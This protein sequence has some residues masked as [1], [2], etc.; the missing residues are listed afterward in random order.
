MIEQ[1]F[2]VATEFRFDVGQAMLNTQAL[3]GAVDNL[4]A[5]TDGA[6]KSLGYLAGGLVAH[7]GFGSG[8]LLSILTKAVQISEAFDSQALNFAN[9]INANMGTLSGTIGTFNERLATSQMILDNISDTAI[10]FAIPTAALAE[11]TQ[12]IAT[13]LANRGKLG[14]NFSGAIEMSKNL[15]LAAPAA[16]INPMIAGESLY[17]ALSEHQP[18]HGQLFSRLANT[19]QFKGAHITTQMQLANMQPDKKIELLSSALKGLA[20]D[21]DAINFR[22]NTLHGQF[23]ILQDIFSD[24]GSILRPIGDAIKKPLIQVLKYLTTYFA[25]HGKELGKNLGQLLSSFISDPKSALVNLMQLKSFGGD[26]K[27]ALHIVE[28][29]GTFRLLKFIITDLLGITLNGGLI[30]KM[31]NAIRTGIMWLVD[32]IPWGAVMSGVFNLLRMAALEV[33]PVFL[34][35]LGIFQIFSRAK[36]IALAQDIKNTLP[37]TERLAGVMVKLKVAFDKIMTPITTVI[38]FMANLIAPLFETTFWLKIGVPLLE[39]LAFTLDKIG[40][41]VVGLT[42]ALYGIIGVIVDFITDLIK[43]KNPFGHVMENYNTNFMDFQKRVATN[44]GDPSKSTSNVVNNNHIEARFDMREQ[45]EPDRIAFAVTE[46]LKKLVLNPQQAAGR[47]FIDAF[48]NKYGVAG[49]R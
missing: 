28:L 23:T 12:K 21:T 43:L 11:L 15:M 35:A 14:T 9:T 45:L 34:A 33:L 3:Q 41:V 42:S 5:S 36:G 37:M 1:L 10:K 32:L 16:N 29:Y 38:D 17:R 46:S 49:N 20:K 13:P 24:I 7:L 44:L 19:P 48:A 2:E 30:I 4:S 39:A 22:L 25:N 40:T 27:K 8:G 6:M 47:S 31:F 18:L 26:F